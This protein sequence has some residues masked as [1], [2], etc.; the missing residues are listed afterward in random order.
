MMR[1]REMRTSVRSQKRVGQ[2]DD[3]KLGLWTYKSG[4]CLALKCP[5]PLQ[6]PGP[7][8]RAKAAA[9]GATSA[10]KGDVFI[11]LLAEGDHAMHERKRNTTW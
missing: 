9:A 8:P 1:V 5:L 7:C 11:R 2:W 6:L 10:G 4:R 3:W